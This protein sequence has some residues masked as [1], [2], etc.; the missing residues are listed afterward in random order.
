MSYEKI[1]VIPEK[2]GFLGIPK[3]IP[4]FAEMMESS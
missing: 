2:A 1:V 4:D 3:K